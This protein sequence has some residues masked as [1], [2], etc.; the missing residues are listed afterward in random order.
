[1]TDVSDSEA[2]TDVVDG[3]TLSRTLGESSDALPLLFSRLPLVEQC[4]A[5]EVNH[6]WCESSR[7]FCGDMAS[8]DLRAHAAYVTDD[9]LTELLV[10]FP[11]LKALNVANCKLLSDVGLAGLPQSNPLLVDLNVACLPLLTADG[12]SRVTDALPK[13]QALELAGC[14]GISA[15]E[16]VQ[17]FARWLELEEDEDGLTACQG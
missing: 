15:S 3:D 6:A 2:P 14:T 5:A 8:L 7:A 1:M 17:R 4:H 16:L 9:T 11:R 13:L 10:K 12:V